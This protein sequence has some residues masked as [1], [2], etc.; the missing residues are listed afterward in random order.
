[1]DI[2][3]NK[4]IVFILF[5]IFSSIVFLSFSNN[6]EKQNKK[7]FK[8]EILLDKD[9]CFYNNDN[10]NLLI[11]LKNEGKWPYRVFKYMIASTYA[12]EPEQFLVCIK[13]ENKEYNY[14]S[15]ILY[16]RPIKGKYLIYK[17][18]VF[19]K[20]YKIELKKLIEKS[21]SKYLFNQ[22]NKNFLCFYETID[23]KNFGDYEIQVQY[24]NPKIDTIYSNTVN[25]VYLNK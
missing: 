9:S 12:Y 18:R 24:Y 22:V 16:K 23:N 10:I 14:F 19:L 25:F 7:K 3:Y 4:K 17:N 2:K 20:K 5:L 8:L 1:M 15:P 6:K 11:T 13:H 21:R